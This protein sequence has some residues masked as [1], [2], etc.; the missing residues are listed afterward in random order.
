MG[1]LKTSALQRLLIPRKTRFLNTE[2][3]LRSILR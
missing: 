1:S 3:I 2:R